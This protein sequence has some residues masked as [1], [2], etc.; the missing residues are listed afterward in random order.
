MRLKTA[1]L[2]TVSLTALTFA[3][4]VAAQEAPVDPAAEAL[5]EAEADPA[6]DAPADDA[7]VVTGLRRS[8][9]SAQN[10][11][12]NSDQIVD[13]IVA[14][15]IGK[16]PDVTASA[17]LARV[18]GVQVQRAAGEAD[19]VQIRGLPDI[20]TTYNGREIFTAND[21]FV[22]IQ[23]FPAGSVAALEVFKS[24]TAN[25]VE[26]G[27][28]GQ[29][30][31]RSRKPFDFSGF[32]LSGSF[33]IVKFTQK[34]DQDWNG[35]L[36]VSNRWDVGDGGEFGLLV[37]AAMTNIDFLD[38]TRESAF[39]M[40]DLGGG[41][42]IPD[43]AGLFYQ[44]G[45]R[46]RPSANFAAEY[47]PS[48]DL[49]FYV[50]GLWQGYR[51]RDS[52]Q[53]LLI[54]LFNGSITDVVVDSKGQ[55]SS[56]RGVG[57]N[58]PDGYYESVKLNTNT[59]QF[60][61]GFS[62]DMG[63][64]LLTAD[65]ART[66]STVKRRQANVD[67]ALATNPDRIVRFNLP[68]T[69]GTSFDLINFDTL[70]P[71]NYL[72][73]GLFLNNEDRGGSDTQARADIEWQTGMAMFPR[74]QVGVRGADR[75]ADFQ[76]GLDYRGSPFRPFA[77]IGLVQYQRPC[78]F[79]YESVQP[80]TC[81][82]G[83][84]YDTVFDNLA[85]LAQRA[86]FPSKDIPFDPLRAFDAKE[87]SLA[88]YAQLRY[89]FDAGFPIDGLIGLRAVNT[90]SEVEGILRT[91]PG[92]VRTPLTVTNRY[93][94]YLP[95]VSMRFGFRSNLQA[96]LAYTETRTK[97]NF[98]DL[99]PGATLDPP[100]GACAIN[101][102]SSTACFR[103]G[104][105]GNPNLAPVESRNYDATIEYYFARQ[106]SL[107]GA[108]FRRDVRNFI[109]RDTVDIADGTVVNFIRY[110]SP[111]NSGKG[112]I[113]GFEVAATA[114]LDFDAV[115]RWARGFGAQANYTYINAS[116]ELSPQFRNGRLPGQQDFPGVSKHSYNLVGIYEQG[117]LSARLA[118]NWRSRFA[119][120][121]LDIQGFQAPLVQKSLGQLDFSASVTPF[122]NI[123]IAF[124]ANNL[125]AGKQPIRTERQYN[126]AGE[127]YDW[128]V[129][130]LERVFSL[131]VR[132]RY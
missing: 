16:L 88:A 112:K 5:A 7:I 90:K 69:G 1:V 30:N 24:S 64:V 98:A 67:Y 75:K 15:D 106:G 74:L 46:Y 108:I 81:F 129:K 39:F 54:P 32:E 97:P 62:Y 70:N 49:R 53:W 110:N 103:N 111:Q 59:Y 42:E 11:K 126:I 61:G 107:T 76:Q 20:S 116:T 121:Y 130:Y 58:N 60:G 123:T 87:R 6:A 79:D 13:A 44:M 72:Y 56:V 94:D 118:Y 14:E 114:F 84:S 40:R 132:F 48:S 96:R 31:V 29:V 47:R 25:L 91:E 57:G 124:D 34:D 21:R 119:R 122:P 109:F 52:N 36:L 22:A 71:T 128:G 41:L 115:P 113:T 10:I 55:V 73:R 120:E 85:G 8:L 83:V 35:N 102:P 93:T 77:Q 28:G 4:P 127:T 99:N 50:D 63:S 23:D 68:G 66:D 117:P 19:G 45:D 104:G 33:N 27:L 95:N 2:C 131:G 12:R 43:I 9:Q 51:G 26:G 89:E 38:S 82:V 100:T 105:G 86:G 80:E 37:N 101:G 17:A 65:V 18:T 78:G 125:L 3:A 92:N